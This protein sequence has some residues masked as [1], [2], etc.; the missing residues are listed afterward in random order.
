MGSLALSLVSAPLFAQAGQAQRGTPGQDTPYILI[1]TFHSTDRK[2]GSDMADELRKRIQSERSAKE[3][4]VIPKTN[5][6]K[7][8]EASGYKADS[9]LNS[10]D[11]MELGKQLRAEQV[12]DGTVDKSGAGVHVTTRVLMKTGQQVVAQPLPPIDAK[13]AGDAAAKIE[14][15]LTEA[16]KSFPNYKTCTSDLRAAK[17]DQAIT[18]ARAGLVAYPK[19]TLA[20]LCILTAYN[21]QKTASPDSIITVSK[22]LL[23][24]DPA[25][26]IALASLADAYKAK[27]DTA[28]ALQTQIQ[29]WRADPQNVTLVKS[30]ILSIANSGSPEKGLPLIDTLLV[31]NPGDPE[32]IRTK[33]L[34]QLRAR[35]FKNA[36][37]TG[38]ELIKADTSAETVDFYTRMIG[39]AQSDSNA[40][41]VGELSSAAAKKFPNDPSFGLL[42]IQTLIKAGQLQQALVAARRSAQAT[43]KDTRVWLMIIGIQQQLNQADSIP[44]TAQAAIA[45]GVPKDAMAVPLTAALAP[46]LQKAQASKTR[47]DWTAVQLAAQSVNGIA[48]SV[49]ASFYYGYASFSIAQDAAQNIQGLVK[50]KPKKDDV[51]KACSEVKVAEDNLAIAQVEVPKGGKFQPA[52]AGQIM[53][54]IAPTSEYVTQVKAA[55]KCK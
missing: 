8:L 33:W 30:I 27:G 10:S 34:L 28:S 21:G 9:A 39:A 7:T 11:L 31:S 2:L 47:D 55:L 25:S 37:A 32:M 18:D 12:I 51:E 42:G 13:D 5:I 45:A 19:S 6:D 35:Q 17:Y 46:L 38:K 53:Q 29:M 4:Y 43:P 20:R 50:G 49:E 44:A 16:A 40:A 36:I 15:A 48:P 54:A 23:E 24:T 3:L 26:M 14:R 52:A 22:A 41:A 1:A